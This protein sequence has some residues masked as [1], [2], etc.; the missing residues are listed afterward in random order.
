MKLPAAGPTAKAAQPMRAVSFSAQLEARAA[1]AAHADGTLSGLD[2][3]LYRRLQ[4]PLAN[5]AFAQTGAGF[6]VPLAAIRPLAEALRAFADEL[7]GGS[8]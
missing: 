4:T 2:L 3:R 6:R 7:E 8:R 5:D 1:I